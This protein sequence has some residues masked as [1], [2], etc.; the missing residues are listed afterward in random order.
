VRKKAYLNIDFFPVWWNVLNRPDKGFQKVVS[1][2]HFPLSGGKCLPLERENFPCC[3]NNGEIIFS[4]N[5]IDECISGKRGI[6][7]TK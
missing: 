3:G 4:H 7:K 5:K 1:K 2:Q 6:F